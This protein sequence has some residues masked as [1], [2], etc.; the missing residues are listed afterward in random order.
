MFV[1]SLKPTGTPEQLEPLREAHQAWAV[2][3]FKDG[4]L[5]AGGRLVP[6][7]GGMLFAANDRLAVD[8]L[9]A[10]EPFRREGLAEVSVS[11]LH[12]MSVASGLEALR[13]GQQD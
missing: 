7:T 9:I 13:T 11:E 4:V 6:P 8:A 2:K 3:G 10:T 12:V 5:L 1:L